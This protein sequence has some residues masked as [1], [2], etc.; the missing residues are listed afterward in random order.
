MTETQRPPP[1]EHQDGH[2]RSLDPQPAVVRPISPETTP[3][4]DPE[5]QESTPLLG[6]TSSEVESV[7]PC[8]RRRSWWTIASIAILLVLTINIIVFAFVVPSAAQSYASQATTYAI[9]NVQIENYT[10]SGV[11]ATAQVNVTIDAS[12]VSSH[13]IRNLGVFATNIFKH[14]YTEPCTVSILLPQ[15]NGAQVALAMLPALNID[16][17]NGHVNILDITSNVT[18]TD[19]S[20]AVHLATDYFAGKRHKLETIG[21]TDIHIKAGIIPL[22]WHHMRQ[23]VIVRGR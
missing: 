5:A 1:A 18:V 16:I 20:L 21:E 15:Y 10:E 14:I 3:D 11:I 2:L 8:A 4:D 13:G 12:R 6:R 22:G 17:R 19:E 7:S 23:E 9:Q